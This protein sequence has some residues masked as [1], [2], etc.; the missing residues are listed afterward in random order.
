MSIPDDKSAP[1]RVP[2]SQHGPPRF[3]GSGINKVIHNHDR[4]FHMV[5]R[6]FSPKAPEYHVWRC[7][8]KGCPATDTHL[9][10]HAA[11]LNRRALPGRL[12]PC[13]VCDEGITKLEKVVDRIRKTL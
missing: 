3:A 9:C 10:P 6:G 7:R 4:P 11:N 12:V 1:A 13:P 5:Y 8:E 2:R